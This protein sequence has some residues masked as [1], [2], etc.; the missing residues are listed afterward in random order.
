MEEINVGDEVLATDPK[1]GKT[2]PRKIVRRIVTEGD[3]HFAD[4]SI[5]A[6]HGT[7]K[8]TATYEHPFWSPS[9][10]KWIKAGELNPGMTLR[11]DTGATVVIVGNRTY[12][13]HA[14]TY[15]LTV[16]IVHTYFVLAGATPVLVHNA[17]C[18]TPLSVILATAE[19]AN[20]L[21]ESLRA[22]GKLPGNYV[23]KA[24]AKA[25]GWEPGKALAN[26]VP[27]GQ[28]GGDV[29]NDDLKMLPAATGRTWFEADVAIDS[30]MKRS[31]QPGTRLVYS[32][33]GLTYVTSDH[34]AS[35]YQ[36]PNWK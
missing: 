30:S 16:D 33:D 8:L 27:G 20:P 23:T 13:R 15:N 36:L 9:E 17:S 21:I 28:I 2:V 6:K 25:A 5:G 31:K 29:F 34:Y 1:S 32:N 19:A 26:K 18:S 14:R 7:E 11:T 10:A 35:F 12:T 22:T 4:L 3:K 24:Q